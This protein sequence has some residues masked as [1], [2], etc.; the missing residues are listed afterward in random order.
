M[1]KLWHI[2]KHILGFLL[3]IGILSLCWTAAYFITWWVYSIIGVRPYDFVIQIV[4]FLFGLF[5]FGW[6]M[7]TISAI[8][9]HKKRQVEFLNSIT[10]AMKQIAKGDFNVNLTKINGHNRPGDPFS[11][12]VDHINHMAKELGQVEEMRQEFV[13]NVSHEIQSPLTSIRGFARALQNETLSPGDRAHYLSIIEMESGR[14]SK[15]S[16]NLLKLTSLESEH[17]PFEPKRYA[18]DKQLRHIVLSSEP[19]WTEKNINMDVALDR[20]E[21]VAD[22]DLMSQVWMNLL[23]NAIKFT[24]EGGTIKI[25]LQR[26]GAKVIVRITDTGIGM[27]VEE[28][29]HIF[30]RFYKA[31][32]SRTRTKGGN[33]LG[34]SI[35]KKIVD[36]HKG[37]INVKSQQGEGTTISVSLPLG[38]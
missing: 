38:S 18:L 34:L 37:E 1:K 8:T 25:D 16:D 24:P 7:V 14:L 2:L 15:L 21:V 23:N 28:Q 10:D 9:P 30:E 35:V 22:H 17:H 27:S 11:D 5:I 19:Q 3:I 6:L 29:L 26:D 32:K 31:D 36:I 12:I 4:N 20:I 33:G 13:S